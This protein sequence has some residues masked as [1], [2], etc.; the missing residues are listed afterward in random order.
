MP[1]AGR[2]VAGVLFALLAWMASQ[3]IVPQFPAGFDPGRFA[4]VNAVIGFLCGW[5]VAGSRANTTWSGA[6]SYGLTATIALVFWGLF[7]HGFAVMIE[8][9]LDKLYDGPV[10]ALADVFGLMFENALLMAVQP[11]VLTLVIGG[12]VA[13]IVTEMA[14]RAWR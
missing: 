10:E 14:A 6:V 4:E 2:L 11:V 9:S 3:L 8:K 12:I 7:V 1:T 5:I 13:G